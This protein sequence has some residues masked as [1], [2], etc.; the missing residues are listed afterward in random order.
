MYQFKVSEKEIRHL[1]LLKKNLPAIIQTFIAL[2][3]VFMV[4]FVTVLL[5]VFLLGDAFDSEL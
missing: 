4:A 5:V 3:L 1:F 2:Y